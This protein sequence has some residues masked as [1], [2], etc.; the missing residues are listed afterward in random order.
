MMYSEDCGLWLGRRS[1]TDLAPSPF[2]SETPIMLT[3]DSAPSPR[4]RFSFPSYL[5]FR[6]SLVP[7]VSSSW[8]PAGQCTLSAYPCPLP[9]LGQKER[10][11]NAGTV[12]KRITQA[13]FHSARLPRGGP[14][15]P[16][17]PF[18]GGSPAGACG[19]FAVAL[20]TSRGRSATQPFP[21]PSAQTPSYAPMSALPNK[22][23]L[24]G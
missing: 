5:V 4:A 3:D 9:A 22:G 20:F 6:L 21:P 16:E 18:L 17:L 10:W 8:F 1:S 19:F 11:A 15:N 24:S 12:S 23:F 13:A 7:V 2:P 14:G